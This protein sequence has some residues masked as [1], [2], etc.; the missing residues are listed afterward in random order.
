MNC[1]KTIDVLID[2]HPIIEYKSNEVI[3]PEKAIRLIIDNTPEGNNIWVKSTY[4]M[5]FNNIIIAKPLDPMIENYIKNLYENKKHIRI[6]Y[7]KH[8]NSAPMLIEG[9]SINK[10]KHLYEIGF[11]IYDLSDMQDVLPH[12][13]SKEL[14]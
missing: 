1:I 8:L 12:I 6:E 5:S 13:S 3:I 11:S 4:P 7:I 10:E 14:K 9:E 2:Y